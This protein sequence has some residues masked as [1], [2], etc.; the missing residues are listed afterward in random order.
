MVTRK[1]GRSRSRSNS[2]GRPRTSKRARYYPSPPRTPPVGGV[3]TRVAA[4]GEPRRVSQARGIVGGAVGLLSQNAVVG[5]QAGRLAGGLASLFSGRKPVI[6]GPAKM[7]GQLMG[8]RIRDSPM[9]KRCSRLGIIRHIE[10]RGTLSDSQCVYM[11]YNAVALERTW[12]NVSRAIIR[13][14]LFK[15]FG[16][17][18]AQMAQEINYSESVGTSAAQLKFDFWDQDISNTQI[19]GNVNTIGGIASTYSTVDG[20]NIVTVGDWLAGVLQRWSPSTITQSPYM[21]NVVRLTVTEVTTIVGVPAY[22]RLF[23]L[24]LNEITVHYYAHCNLKIQNRT[25]NDAGDDDANDVNDVP[26]QGRCY[27]FKSSAVCPK[28]VTSKFATAGDG[29]ILMNGSVQTGADAGLWNEPPQKFHFKNCAATRS[30]KMNPGDIKQDS[31]TVAYKMPLNK[32]L[33]LCAWRNGG[34]QAFSRF[35]YNPGKIHMFAMEKCMNFGLPI[36]VVYEIDTK[37]GCYITV[38][39]RRNVMTALEDYSGRDSNTV[40]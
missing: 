30:L 39:A 17:D 35:A 9:Y 37:E 19:A 18:P 38:N 23:E 36:S 13:Y 7:A 16:F 28:H 15:A 4:R 27:A 33:T 10:K 24:N 34:G 20:D 2:R 8:D 1:R 25:V 31:M 6:Y 32:W 14:V 29:L 5:Q 12:A 11:G 3:R 21:T 40:V 22:R 26:L